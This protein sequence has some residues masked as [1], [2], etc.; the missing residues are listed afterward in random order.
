LTDPKVTAIL[1]LI[2][3]DRDFQAGI[4]ALGGYNLRDCGKVM[5]EQ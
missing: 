5:Y 1:E 3:N 4:L 2:R